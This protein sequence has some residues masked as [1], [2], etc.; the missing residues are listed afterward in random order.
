MNEIKRI[1]PVSAG[2]IVGLFMAMVGFFIGLMIAVVSVI[3][4]A[5]GPTLFSQ[6][7]QFSQLSAAGGQSFPAMDMLPI[8]GLVGVVA[9]VA[10]PV[11]YGVVGFIWGAV[12]AAVY[13]L[14]ARR[15]G[16]VKVELG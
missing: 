10:F 4:S 12:G 14:L 13:N 11:I 1:E 16:G 5:V 3:F 6:L 15:I 8:F 2:K 9:I 7:S